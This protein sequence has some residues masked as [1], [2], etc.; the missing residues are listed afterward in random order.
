MKRLYETYL[1]V[2]KEG[3]IK[4]KV[5]ICRI[6]IAVVCMVYC[7]AAMGFSAYA[8]F[9]SI[10]TS[11]LNTI[12]AAVY[13]AEIT[14]TDDKAVVEA[15][16]TEQAV[17]LYHLTAGKTYTVT[18]QAVGTASSGYCKVVAE[19]VNYYTIPMSPDEKQSNHSV[20]FTVQCYEDATIRMIANWGSYCVEDETK[21]IGNDNYT[22]TIGATE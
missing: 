21:V 12:Q 10:I 16:K 6:A 4:E 14:F 18:I 13:D 8:Y 7:L 15:V 20:T 5:F 1:H 19:D 11:G 2:P 22:I 9:S 17:N 3:K